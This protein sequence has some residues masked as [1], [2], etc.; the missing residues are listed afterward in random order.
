MIGYDVIKTDVDCQARNSED[1]RVTGSWI[2]DTTQP[3]P[4]PDMATSES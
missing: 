1:H 2:Y 4:P 3:K